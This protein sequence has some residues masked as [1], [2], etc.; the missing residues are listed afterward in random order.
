MKVVTAGEIAEIC[1][2]VLRG[3]PGVAVE[4][5]ATLETARKGDLAVL[6]EDSLRGNAEQS[7]ASVLVAREDIDAFRGTCI[8]VQDPELALAQLL[9]VFYRRPFPHPEGISEEAFISPDAVLGRDVTVGRYSVIESGA[10]LGDGCI[11][12]PLV[13]IGRDVRIGAGTVIYPHACIIGPAS[14]GSRCTIR[15]GAVIGDEGFGFIQRD[16]TSRRLRHTGGVK[17]G[18][19]VEVGALSSIDRGMLDDT[20]AGDGCKLDKHCMI[21]HNCRIGNDC[22]LAGY[23]RMA[24][25]VVIG[26]GAILAADVRISDHVTIGDNAILAAGTG[27]ARDIKPEEVV[28]GMPARP[29]KTQ[30]RINALV[31]RLPDLFRRVRELE[32]KLEDRQAL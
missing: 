18:D 11:I 12:F 26:N 20:V 6:K 8:V 27:A 29:I 16:G 10:D 28:W 9:E 22:I 19:D 2:G 7:R 13:Y 1:G 21:A 17:I 5:L 24:G 4:G 23:A 32:K 31:G 25:S 3:D 14:I 15:P 30:N